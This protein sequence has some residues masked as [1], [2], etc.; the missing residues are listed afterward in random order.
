MFV[1][2]VSGNYVISLVCFVKLC[3]HL[4]ILGQLA[5]LTRDLFFNLMQHF[6]IKLLNDIN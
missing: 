4:S 2:N 5:E 1:F 3:R 6:C